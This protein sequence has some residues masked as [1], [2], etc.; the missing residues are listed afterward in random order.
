MVEYIHVDSTFEKKLIELRNSKSRGFDPVTTERNY[1]LLKLKEFQKYLPKS[2]NIKCQKEIVKNK[3]FRGLRFVDKDSLIIEI[4]RF[5]RNT[6]NERYRE[7]GLVEI[8]RIFI[9]KGRIKNRSFK[10]GNEKT[11][12]IEELENGWIYE[13]SQMDSNN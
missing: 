9:S 5:K 2:W 6:L 10:Y 12:F 11:K 4:D 7:R 13:I 1:R 8:H 3:D